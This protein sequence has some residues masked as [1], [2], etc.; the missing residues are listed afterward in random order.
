YC[1]RDAKR[2]PEILRTHVAQGK[3]LTWQEFEKVFAE[4][5]ADWNENHVVGDRPAPPLAMYAGHRGPVPAA[6]TVAFLSQKS[7]PRRVR[8]EGVTLDGEVWSAPGLAV[9]V[10][11]N[12]PCRWDVDG[13]FAYVPD[14][15]AEKPIQLRP[16]ER[17]VWGA[18]NGANEA[19]KRG[20]KLQREHL[21][22]V[23][24]ELR[25]ACTP[26]QLDPTGA[27]R[28]VAER[29]CVEGADQA[30]AAQGAAVRDKARR[31]AGRYPEPNFT[32]YDLARAVFR[33][34]HGDMAE[35]VPVLEAA[36][37]ADTVDD[38]DERDAAL[39]GVAERLRSPSIQRLIKD[40]SLGI[41]EDGL[42]S[43]EGALAMFRSLGLIDHRNRVRRRIVGDVAKKGA[44]P[45]VSDPQLDASRVEA[46]WWAAKDLVALEGAERRTKGE[47]VC[48]AETRRELTER[49]A[50]LDLAGADADK[51]RFLRNVGLLTA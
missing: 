40:A 45:S 13:A 44:A 23:A 17:A 39:D 28:V 33:C 6:E 27:F 35:F 43:G 12:V 7:A 48:Q 8:P 24:A 38:L 5:V 51:V 16:V 15:R 14:G 26:D 22:S 10:G 25:G 1:G 21:R 19:A 20:A 37:E 47:K 30:A 11:L 36:Y 9:L 46:C 32:V 42:G 4:Q 2:R 34:R 41:N 31:E 18:F 50:G 49:L 3:L 29:L